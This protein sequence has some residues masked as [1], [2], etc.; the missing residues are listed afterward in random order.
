MAFLLGIFI[1]LWWNLDGEI[2]FQIKCILGQSKTTNIWTNPENI[3][4]IYGYGDF[5]RIVLT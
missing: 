5:F 4:N 2:L 1:Q 3:K